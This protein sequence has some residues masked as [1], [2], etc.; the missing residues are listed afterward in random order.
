MIDILPHV[1]E[2][3]TLTSLSGFEALIRG[4]RVVTYGKPFYAGWGLTVDE[5]SPEVKKGVGLTLEE[6]VGG[7]LILYPSCWD[8]KSHIFCRPEDVCFRIVKGE[9]PEVGPWIRF[10]RVIRSIRRKFS[11]N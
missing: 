1:D 4:K 7:T 3:H 8:W 2:V 6:L 11:K 5:A 9:Q 10:C